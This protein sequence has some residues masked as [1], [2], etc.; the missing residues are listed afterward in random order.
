MRPM[1]EPHPLERAIAKV[2]LGRLA[3]AIGKTHQAM[4]KWQ[5]AG[6]MPRTEWTGETRYA[7][8]IADLCDGAPSVQE[9]LGPWPKWPA[10]EA[11]EPASSA[12]RAGLIVTPD[13]TG[14]DR[15]T[16]RQGVD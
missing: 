13:Y 15:R 7:Q 1:I 14:P 4:R 11:A 9:L 2:G 3:C 10:T 12:E 6:R 8:R 5:R 16:A